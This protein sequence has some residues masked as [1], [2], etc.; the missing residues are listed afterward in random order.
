M[1]LILYHSDTYRELTMEGADNMDHYLVLDALEYHL[2]RSVRLHLEVT[3]HCWMLHG[4]PAEYIILGHSADT[5]LPLTDGLAVTL[6]TKGGDRLTLVAVD[7]GSTLPVTRKFALAG[8]SRLRFG[9]GEDN[10]IRYTFQELVSK[11]H[12][13]LYH[14]QD[15]WYLADHSTNGTYCNGSK[16][17]APR[18]LVFGD[19]IQLFGLMAVYLGSVLCLVA[20]GGELALNPQV[21]P[22]VHNV[23]AQVTNSPR[24]PSQPTRY[25]NRSPRSLP[26]LFRDKL[27]IE[28][29]PD[30]HFPRPRP[31]LL[32][33][34]PSL[35]MALPML[36]G[37]LLAIYGS[38]SAGLRGGAFLYTGLVTA[39]GSAALGAVWALANLRHQNRE[40]YEAERARINAYSNYLVQQA[41]TLRQQYTAN[42]Q[43]LNATY[44]PPSTLCGYQANSPQLWNRDPHHPDFLYERL[45]LGSMPFQV[46]I[47]IPNRKF[48]LQKDPLQEKPAE[49]RQQF[50]RLQNVPL[51]I[52]LAKELLVG[53][54]GGPGKRGAIPVVYSLLAGLAANTCYTD[55]KIAMVCAEGDS[56]A[57]AQWNFVKWLPHV[58]NE[59]HTTRYFAVGKTEA[60]DVFYEL[61]N[62]LRGRVR[63]PESSESRRQA[64]HPHYVLF[65]ED[66]ALLEGEMITKYLYSRDEALGITTVLLAERAEDLPNACESI[67]ENTTHFA[68]LLHPM[69]DDRQPVRFDQPSLDEMRRQAHAL[70]GLQ[71][72]EPESGAEIPDQLDF[73]SMFGVRRLDELQVADRWRKNRTYTSMRVPIGVKAGG[74]LCCLDI[75]EK[76][77]GPH[78]LVAGTTGSGKSETLQTYILSLALNFSPEDVGFFLIDFKGG[79]MAN[80]FSGLPH[81]LGQISNLSGN[82]VH[83]AMISIKSENR[84][85]QRLFNEYDVNNINQYTRL[86]KAGECR[87]PIPHLFIIIDEFAELKREEPDFMRELISVAQVGRSLGVHLILATQKPSGTVDDNIWSNAKFRL[88]LRVQDRQDSND[89]LHKPDAAFI[90][91][92]GR[93]YLQVGNDE[94]YEQFQSAWSGAVYDEHSGDGGKAVATLLTRTG[95]TGI[96]GSRTKIKRRERE[97]LAWLTE[98]AREVLNVSPAGVRQPAEELAEQVAGGPLFREGRL[99]GSVPARQALTN[100]LQLWPDGVTDAGEAAQ[101]ILTSAETR[102]LSL[103]APQEK[104][105]LDALVEYL[106][107]VARK[108]QIRSGPRLWLPVLPAMLAQDTLEPARAD[109]GFRLPSAADWNLSVP[110]GLVDDPE[111]QLQTPLT[112]DLGSSHLAVCGSVFSGKSTLLQT[113]CYGLVRRYPADWVNLYLLDFSSHLL[114]CLEEAPQVGGVMDESDLDRVGNFFFLLDRILDDRKKQLKGGN[115]RQFVRV[116]G[117]TMPSIVVVID[118]YA[119]FAEKTENRYEASILRA[120]REGV[121]YGIF[122]VLSAAEFGLNGIPNRIAE[123][124]KT[125]LCLGLGDKF[126]YME[127]LHVGSVPVLPEPGTPGRGLAIV[128]KVPLEFQTAVA[129]EAPDDYTRGRLLADACRERRSAWTGAPARP[130]PCIPETPT[131]SLLQKAPD[132]APLQADPRWLPVGYD[133]RSAA[134]FAV[135]L[136]QTYCYTILGRERT[137][138]TNTLKLLMESAA[139]KG[140][141]LVVYEHQTDNRPGRLQALAD[142]LG[143]EYLDSDP[144]LFAFW[145]EFTPEFVRRNK[146]KLALEA[147]GRTEA[148]LYEAMKSERPV[149]IF[150]PDLADFFRAVYTPDHGTGNMKGFMETILKK[151]ALHNIFFFGCLRVDQYT[152]LTGRPGFQSYISRVSGMLLG[153]N[154]AGQRLFSFQNIP[155]AQLSKP[156]P[157]GT[158][159][160][161]SASDSSQAVTVVLP[162]AER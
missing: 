25:I 109:G 21:L 2:R 125:V 19:K 160:A 148:E 46:E 82:Q 60:S 102:C 135:D 122:L 115:Y 159:L 73:L 4:E 85:R 31:L 86:Y 150:L 70:A 130:V 133:R 38:Q 144:A 57:L 37:A 15:G 119:A 23:A 22:E 34:G 71:V 9:S 43:A 151:G 62:I 145:Q 116:N 66:A 13:E 36:L 74:A 68:G 134:V 128:D 117:V 83:R 45:G 127:L 90:T 154:A 141:R 107:G 98:L 76:F 155:F 81:L 40:Q 146:R 100:F 121:G 28:A 111:N 20:R 24:T 118:N 52:D 80:L 108:E 65:V 18:R 27:T 78:G 137:G 101:A 51:G 132:Y 69:Q 17:M 91:Q 138:R 8:L 136:A 147:E 99:T 72:H 152:G 33:I 47:E 142:R 16:V 162:L 156:M 1:F 11:H 56:Q 157:R 104:T 153:G 54:V 55:V 26:E 161:A 95:K 105:Q 6:S 87:Q 92:A 63:G 30:A 5:P 41:D 58:W 139:D 97:R 158:A 131:F 149:C 44:P 88:C 64:P 48:S 143:A 140:A 120:A 10:D 14:R 12:G 126:K 53:V 79:G 103:P 123:N 61:C 84:R 35:T 124:L 89:M 7:H 93:C 112:V 49:I 67:I 3:R 129:L 75:H 32:T 106:A 39:V 42:T 110:V 59:S 50:S 77:H 96:V 94:I 29:V 114:S 113:L